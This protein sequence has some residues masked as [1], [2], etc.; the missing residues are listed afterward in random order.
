MGEE[1]VS[2]DMMDAAG[3]GVVGG[4]VSCISV[5]EERLASWLKKKHNNQPGGDPHIHPLW[6]MVSKFL[7]LLLCC[8]LFCC[9]CCLSDA[10]F[11]GAVFVVAA[12]FVAAAF[13]VSTA[14]V[15]LLLLFLLL[16]FLLLC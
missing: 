12:F 16:L 10:V 7:L 5:G 4:H 13:I 14:F 3:F 6:S 1:A 9:C 15:L 8:C 2:V 11:A